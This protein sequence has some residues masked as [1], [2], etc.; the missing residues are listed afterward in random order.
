MARKV[1]IKVKK[2]Q[3]ITKEEKPITKASQSLSKKEE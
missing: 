2:T 1:I 3:Q